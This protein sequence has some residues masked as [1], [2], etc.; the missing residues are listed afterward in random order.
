MTETAEGIANEQ[1]A[2]EL[3][4][5]LQRISAASSEPL[6]GATAQEIRQAALAEEPALAAASFEAGRPSGGGQEATSAEFVVGAPPVEDPVEEAVVGLEQMRAGR[7]PSARQALY[8]AAIVLRSERPTYVIDR[9]WI[10][11]RPAAPFAGLDDCESALRPKIRAIGR[12]RSQG[13]AYGGVVGTGFVVGPGLL[14]TNRHVA[15]RFVAGLGRQD[16]DEPARLTFVSGREPSCDLK[17]EQE[18]DDRVPLEVEGAVLMHPYWDI[19]LLRVSGSALAEIEPLRLRSAAV[20]EPAGR[21][22]VL[23]GYPVEAYLAQADLRELRR[24]LFAGR[25]GI[26]RLMPGRLLD[27][28]TSSTLDPLAPPVEGGT[29]ARREV[30]ALGH[31]ASTL[32]GNS[33]SAVMDPTTGAVLGV[34]FRGV[35]LDAN[36]AVPAVELARDP[37]LA[38]LGVQFDESARGLPEPGPDPRVEAAWARVPSA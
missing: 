34:H 9:D 12:I 3:T 10:L 27:R 8:A 17:A 22:V 7:R 28:S 19:A 5:Y 32:S 30:A 31:D 11:G 36:F 15:G 35:S 23:V 38:D 13:A 26:K 24:V 2:D 20:D 6:I 25:F 1:L 16:P 18:N 37:R 4:A 33:G 14:L 21:E 29:A